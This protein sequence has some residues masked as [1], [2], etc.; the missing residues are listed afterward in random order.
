MCFNCAFTLLIMN[1]EI[2]ESE[3]YHQDFTTAS[4]WEIFIARMEEVIHEWR[5]EICKSLPEK[6]EILQGCWVFMREKLPFADVEFNLSLYRNKSLWDTRANND[7]VDDEQK[8][9]NPMDNDYD[10]VL[11]DQADSIAE[12]CLASWYGLKEYIV[13]T[14]T[15]FTS[16]LSESRIKI[17]L[18][19]ANIAIANLNCEIPIFVQIGEKW[20]RLYLGVHECNGLRTNFEMV[21][22]R[23]GPNHCQYLTGLL[24]LFKTKVLSPVTLEHV[25]VSVQLSY[26]LSDFGKYS[27]KQ[28]IPD[29]ENEHFDSTTLCMLPFGVTFDPINSLILKATWSHLPDHLIVDSENYTDFDPM[30]A[31]KWSVRVN[32]TEQPVCL[33]SDCLTDFL[34]L[35]TNNTTIYDVLG[36]YA[37]IPVDVT[38]PLDLLTES[39]VPTISSVLKRAARN[40]LSLPKRGAAPLS[41]E[42]LVPMLYFLFPDAEENPLHPYP[43]VENKE[44]DH[45]FVNLQEVV[46]SGCFFGFLFVYFVF[47]SFTGSKF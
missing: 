24:D 35:L 46:R 29:T 31:P 34:H 43:D 27:W 21:H 7:D 9:R 16:P 18:S 23:K 19:S 38:N 22:L 17:L 20:Q 47:F 15:I 30:Q 1:E 26:S 13:L 32:L 36:D 3:F 28:E 39:K 6:A 37:S 41:E 33:L 4:E 2:D 10:F 8:I 40:S 14:P 42:I 5:L 45:S 11:S 12:L 44:K 25:D